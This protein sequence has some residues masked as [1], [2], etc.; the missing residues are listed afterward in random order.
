VRWV[1]GGVGAVTAPGM[2]AF[3]ALRRSV[4]HEAVQVF[5]SEAPNLKLYRQ[6]GTA[7]LPSDGTTGLLRTSAVT[8]VY[9][10]RRLFISLRQL[11]RDAFVSA[12]LK[13]AA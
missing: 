1:C 2:S 13:T 8:Y 3:G 6:S 12:S 5:E 4:K 11:A 10:L 7:R 9:S